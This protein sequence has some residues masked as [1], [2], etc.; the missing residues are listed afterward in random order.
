MNF[1]RNQYRGR[2]GGWVLLLLPAVLCLPGGCAR[3][4]WNLLKKSG[5]E[6]A[7][8]WRSVSAFAKEP[9]CSFVDRVE[10]APEGESEPETA[11]AV[12]QFGRG[13]Q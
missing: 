2:K 7:G 3:G 6:P 1:G 10:D 8:P 4:Q 12:R 11:A 5:G 9:W 13:D